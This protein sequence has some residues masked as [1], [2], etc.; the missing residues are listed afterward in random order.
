MKKCSRCDI[1]KPLSDF[2]FI[3]TIK[4]YASRCKECDKEYGKHWRD[5]NPSFRKRQSLLN[6]VWRKNNKD[7]MSIYK[8]NSKIRLQLLVFNHYTNNN[9]RCQCI[10]CSE[11]NIGFLTI[12][13]INNDGAK[14]RKAIGSLNLYSWIKQNNY[15]PGFQV[16]CFNCNCG[17]TRN[18][19]NS[20]PH[21]KPILSI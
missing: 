2:Y 21:I 20:C 3:T 9:I 16:L 8:R 12:D 18:I 14:H 4:K 13:H 17:K 6:S 5:N 10:G 1:V 7:K 19:D 11:T 15:P